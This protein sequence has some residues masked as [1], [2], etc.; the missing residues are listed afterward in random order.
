MHVRQTQSVVYSS[1]F[2]EKVAGALKVNPAAALIGA[3]EVHLIKGEGFGPTPATDAA[4]FA[5][6]EADFT[7][8]N[9]QV[10]VLSA[11]VNI[12]P[13]VE[14]VSAVVTFT[15]ITD[16][17]VVGNT[18]RGWW[19]ED[20]GDVVCSEMFP[21]DQSVQL[22]AVGDQLVLVISLPLQCFQ[23]VSGIE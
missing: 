17:T 2:L 9:F 22:A 12:G 18:V 20:G 4:A 7:D 23:S 13:S 5:A 8:Y 15:L 19:M 21:E 14:G 3:P 10:P 16:P 11:P 6:V 1:A